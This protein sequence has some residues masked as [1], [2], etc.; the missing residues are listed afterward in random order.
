[1][2]GVVYLILKIVCVYCVL[3]FYI[4]RQYELDR[5]EKDL[6]YREERLREWTTK[7]QEK[8]ND[9]KQRL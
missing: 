8:E 9:Y 7:L 2:S 3:I 6:H 4:S 5:K 1:M